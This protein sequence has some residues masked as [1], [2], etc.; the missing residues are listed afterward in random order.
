MAIP[1]WRAL[2][3][4]TPGLFNARGHSGLMTRTVWPSVGAFMEPSTQATDSETLSPS[5]QVKGLVQIAL[6]AAAGAFM[7][8]RMSRGALIL[9]LGLG[10]A[11]YRQG[12]APKK[13][14]HEE[15]EEPSR[16]PAEPWV[17][18]KAAA[19]DLATPQVAAPPIHAAPP[20]MLEEPPMIKMT[21]C[22]PSSPLMMADNPDEDDLTNEM[23]LVD[24]DEESPYGLL[25]MPDSEPSNQPV[26]L[27]LAESLIVAKPTSRTP[28]PASAP[29]V[30]PKDAQERKKFFD[31]LRG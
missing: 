31:W 2:E 1:A 8:S 21:L 5:T 10:Y 27:G 11:L 14:A 22:E 9:T 17:Q 28:N 26:S 20:V 3:K 15:P 16:I 18:T 24:S 19:P 25:L 12:Q 6:G 30:V 7:A 4:N 13:T 23:G 29:G